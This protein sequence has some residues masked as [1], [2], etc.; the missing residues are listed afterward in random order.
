MFDKFCDKLDAELEEFEK[1][2][3]SSTAGFVL[4][5][6]YE[7]VVKRELVN[8]LTESPDLFET[9][10]VADQGRALSTPGILD[11]FYSFWLKSDFSILDV[12]TDF[13]DFTIKSRALPEPQTKIF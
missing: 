2:L 6:A 4:D 1:Q 9:W 13:I 12:L 5:H 8:K 10:S 7:L 3:K 11:W